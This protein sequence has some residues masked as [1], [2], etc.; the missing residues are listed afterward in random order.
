[1][2]KAG[3]RQTQSD[4]TLFVKHQ[5]L[6]TTALIVYVDD[7]VVT[8]ND[9]VDIAR[10]MSNLAREFEIK[11][12]RSLKYFLGIEVA[13]SKQCIILSQREYVLDL[14]K[15]SRTRGCKPCSMP[16]KANHRLKENDSVQL[17]DT[18]RY[19]KLVGRL[20]YLSLTRPDIIYV[21]SVISQFIHALTRIT[22]KQHISSQILRGVQE[23]WTLSSRGVYRCRLS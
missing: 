12:L 10:L 16:I 17:I 22:W 19:Q 18:E 1:M 5:A 21:V 13:K 7:I 6:K 2:V 4:H 15:E 8:R 23:K 11:D 14:L 3:Y 20:V 9:D